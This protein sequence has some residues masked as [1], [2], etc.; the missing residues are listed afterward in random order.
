[1]RFPISV[2]NRKPTA[3]FGIA[4]L[5]LAIAP[6]W[7]LLA[8]ANIAA[9][10][11]ASDNAVP[12]SASASTTSSPADWTEFHRDNMQ[13]WNL[14]ETVLGVDNAGSLEVKWK[15]S[16]GAESPLAVVNGV[17]YFSG[18]SNFD[19]YAL[20]AST[21]VALWSYTTGGYVQASPAVANGVVYVGSDKLYALNASTGALLWSYATGPSGGSS[22]TVANGVVYFGSFDNNVYALNGTTGAKLWSYSAGRSV[23]SSPAVAN[24]VVYVGSTDG[25]V[26]ALNASTGALV[27]SFDTGSLLA[28]GVESSPAVAN[29]VVY[30]GSD[31]GSVYAFN[32]ST[33]AKLWNYATGS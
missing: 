22:P 14:Y 11:Q 10:A 28:G 5:L 7:L 23:D 15:I 8:A 21:G 27:W 17:V 33:G 4:S 20:N 13:R 6:L 30:V 1:M 24:G 25:K 31:G 29:G 26:Y 19:L 2:V 9:H 3:S 16:G 18:A 12:S 32:A